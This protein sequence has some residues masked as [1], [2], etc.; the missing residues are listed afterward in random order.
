[1]RRPF[2]LATSVAATLGLMSCT[3]RAES[4]VIASGYA[5]GL[6]V[7]PIEDSERQLPQAT[8]VLRLQGALAPWLQ[9]HLELRGRIGGPFEGGHFGFYDFVHTFQN[10][11]PAVEARAAYLDVR[12]PRA[13]VRF[14]IQGVPW[15]KLDGVPPTDVINPRDFHDP[16]VMDAEEARIG[17]PALKATYGLGDAPSLH[18]AGLRATLVGIPF[19]V[20]SRLPLLQERWFPSAALPTGRIVLDREDLEFNLDNALDHY[21]PGHRGCI[22]PPDVTVTNDVRVRRTVQTGNRRPPLT[23]NAGGIAGRLE[24]AW[25]D[26]DWAVE[27]YTG[28]ETGPDLDLKV[29][30]V[31]QNLKVQKDDPH[32]DLRGLMSRATLRQRHDVIHMTGFETATT[33]GDA[34]IRAEAAFFENRP[35][36]R[37]AQ[38]LFTPER[39]RRVRVPTSFIGTALKNSGCTRERPCRGVVHLGDLFP[40]RDS[41][42]WGVGLDYLTHGVFMLVQLNQIVLREPAP[43][44]IIDNPE[45]RFTGVVR[46]RFLQDRVELEVRAAATVTRG[47]WFV[48]PRVSYTLFDALRLRLGYLAI[49]GS[50]NSLI[51]QFGRNDELVLEARYSF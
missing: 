15:G 17:V 45:T 19:A 41:V 6:A 28:P 1:M 44:L 37:I 7:V 22:D 18:V 29:E 30:V 42:E 39:L 33:L 21:C 36:L 12:L 10:Y 2:L 26:V 20:P 23:L 49:G 14:G 47:G 38:D 3:V 51:G 32:V 13:D 50:R 16:F 25:R 9:G 31:H 27:H 11:S 43:R 24:G 35:Y 5:D 8:G 48:F 46:R 40:R 34:S 4:H